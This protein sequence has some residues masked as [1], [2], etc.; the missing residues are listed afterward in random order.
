VTIA[1][2]QTKKRLTGSAQLVNLAAGFNLGS[3]ARR[4][5]LDG[6]AF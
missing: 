2:A 5:S 1:T 3:L 4:T 6:A